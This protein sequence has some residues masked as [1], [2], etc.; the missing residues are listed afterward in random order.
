MDPKPKASDPEISQTSTCS[1]HTCW[2]SRSATTSI[3]STVAFQIMLNLN[4]LT[5]C[6]SVFA[7]LCLGRQQRWWSR[8]LTTLYQSSPSKT[9]RSEVSLSV[10]DRHEKLVVMGHWPGT[11]QEAFICAQLRQHSDPL[12]VSQSSFAE[13]ILTGTKP[14]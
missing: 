14:G 5:L 8:A 3:T 9:K 10:S 13:A 1:R 4:V 12:S 11:C 2:P 6:G 7:A